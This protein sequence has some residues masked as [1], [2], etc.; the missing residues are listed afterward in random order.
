MSVVRRPRFEIDRA[1]D[2]RVLA[3]LAPTLGLFSRASLRAQLHEMTAQRR[4]ICFTLM[5]PVSRRK[6]ANDD[7]H[8]VATILACLHV[9][10]VLAVEGL[11][12]VL[13][14][15]AHVAE[16]S[17]DPIHELAAPIPEADNTSAGFYREAIYVEGQ[18]SIA[19]TTHTPLRLPA[20]AM[21]AVAA[22]VRG[23]PVDAVT[24][25]A[26]APFHPD[27]STLAGRAATAPPTL[28]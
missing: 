27:V 6:A 20:E 3:A 9:A 10:P 16:V 5:T 1:Y 18:A 24:T 2:L 13:Q 26:I 17:R 22:L 19:L 14:I 4:A 28:H 12:A 11:E 21:Q 23:T 25:V 15:V 7:A 8:A